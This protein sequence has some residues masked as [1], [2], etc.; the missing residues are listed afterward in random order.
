MIFTRREI[1]ER[2]N[3]ISS[4]VA[5][6]KLRQILNLLN[7]EGNQSNSKR[8]LESLAWTWE[9]S[10]V[11]SFCKLGNTK[12]E[13]KISNG[14]N[15]DVFFDDHGVS[16]LCDVFTVSDDQQHRKNPV[17]E[18][19]RLLSEIWKECGPE[20]GSLSWRVESIDLDP[21]N[22]S[23]VPIT[24]SLPFHLSSRARPINRRSLTRLLLPPSETMKEYLYSKVS[25]FFKSLRLSPTPQTLSVDE[26]YHKELRV[27]FSIRYAPDGFGMSGSYRSYTPIEDIERHVVWGRLEAKRIQFARATEKCPRVLIVCD[28]GCA[29]LRSS[30]MGT[31]DYAFDEILDHFWRRPIYSVDAG[32][33]WITETDISA[34]LVLSVESNPAI[35]GLPEREFFLKPLL[36]LNPY[37][38]FP[39]KEKE[40]ALLSQAV[41]TIPT[42]I[43]SPSNVLRFTSSNPVSTRHN[44]TFTMSSK[45]LEISSITLLKILAGE[46]SAEEFCREYQLDFNPFKSALMGF[47]TI[48]K[49]S[50]E[51]VSNR[52]DDKIII[53]LKSYDA[54][55]GP[56]KAPDAD[57]T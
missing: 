17:E 55:I 20:K 6:R 44:G 25:P 19:S 51:S 8:I 48:E 41:S 21:V 27:C 29:G 36:F 23:E 42:P 38:Q 39:L 24:F 10:V 4:I 1:Q 30:V 9:I 53:Q 14:K 13:M 28:G 31:H 15:P 26:N 40:T 3:I 16:L 12:Y 5:K 49:I 18:F 34:V 11:A 56:F 37:C 7:I 52:D 32:W 22:A 46:L 45:H 33:S 57:K 50:L 43:E 35:F 47:Q 2:L 54:S